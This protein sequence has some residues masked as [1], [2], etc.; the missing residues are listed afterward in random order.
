METLGILEP[1]QTAG[2]AGKNLPIRTPA[3][4]QRTTHRVKYF[5]KKPMPVFFFYP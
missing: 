5:S 4:M 3:A 2:R 1:A